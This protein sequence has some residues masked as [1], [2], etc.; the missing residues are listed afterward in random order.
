MV[1]RGAK[2]QFGGELVAGF[3]DGEGFDRILRDVE[4]GRRELSGDLEAVDE[5]G[6]VAGIDA[7]GGETADDIGEGHKDGVSI[8]ERV[9]HQ[10]VL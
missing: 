4:G 5:A 6:R 8:F 3:C 10:G 1:V 9:Q 2:G 7:S